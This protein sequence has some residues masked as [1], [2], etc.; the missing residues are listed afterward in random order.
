MRVEPG[1]A[2]NGSCDLVSVTSTS[3]HTALNARTMNHVQSCASMAHAERSR[4][5]SPAESM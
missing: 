3:R 5:R 4:T 1:G 2:T